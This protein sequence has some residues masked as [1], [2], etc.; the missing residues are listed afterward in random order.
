MKKIGPVLLGLSL[1]VLGSWFTAAQE[2]P[3]MPKVLQVTREFV[4]PGKSGAV[5]DRSESAFVQAMTRA[6]WPT[7][8]VAFNSLSGK[9]R[10]LYITAY[11]SF[12]AWQKDM[13]ATDK[14][15]TLS[16]QLERAEVADGELLNSMDEAV[17][18]YDEDLSYR[19]TPDLA[20]IRFM[21]ITDI[22]IRPGHG[23]DFSDLVKMVIDGHKKAGDN[24]NWATY[25]LSYGGG[26][27][28]IIFSADKSLADIDEGF[29]D[30]KKFRDAMGDEGMAKLISLEQSITTGVDSELFAIN[31][32]QSYPPPSWVEENP[33][34]WKPKPAA[35]AA[36]QPEE[37][38]K[39]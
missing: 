26:D 32:K 21:E 18:Y 22:H 15:A 38:K 14:D 12:E 27:E 25:E 29:A 6:K 36:K 34:F 8:Y 35:P 16:A 3:S 10:A 23:K 19:P 24:A 17:L 31:P 20:N 11:P 2:T 5:H 4:K 30:S 7:H 37:K 33:G 1:A 13:D 28:Y 39:P 9:V